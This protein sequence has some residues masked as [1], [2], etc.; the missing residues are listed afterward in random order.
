MERPTLG[1]SAV[2]RAIAI[3]RDL[4][5]WPFPVGSAGK[6]LHCSKDPA[7]VG[8]GQFEYATFSEG[9]W[10]DELP[11]SLSKKRPER[12]LLNVG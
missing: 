9:A 10:L 8:V 3:N 7:M 2:Q 11:R 12:G 5:P 6:V 4:A 1:G